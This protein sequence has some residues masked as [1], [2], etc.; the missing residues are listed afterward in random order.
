MNT[1]IPRIT[2]TGWSVPFAIRKNDDPIFDWLRKN[3]PDQD[4]FEGYDE[5]HVLQPNEGL[6]DIMVP[7]AIMALE[8]AGK[9]P[10]DI[11]ILLGLGSISEYV[12]PNMLTQVHKELGLSSNAWVIPIGNDYSNYASCLLF[13]D[14]LVKAGKAENV[15]IC[16]GGNWTRNVDYHTP[17]SISAADGAGAAVVSLSDDVSKWF[18]ADY[19][20]VTN[21]AN[22]GTMFTKAAEYAVS[23]LIGYPKIYSNHF[24]QITGEGLK[25]FGTFGMQQA[26]TAVL[27]LLKKNNL[28]GDDISFMPHQTSQ[29][30]VDYWLKQIVPQPA[31]CL[32]TMKKFAN[33]TVATHALNLA[34]FEENKSIQKDNL[35]MLALGPDMHA[36]AMLLK[37]NA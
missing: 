8:N 37:R 28:T 25:D 18:V 9:Q 36:N 1:L 16:I 21:S 5:R 27:E 17:Q 33:V 35:V 3:L 10:D 22:Y 4:M 24:F 34:W 30:L 31:Q 19:C 2:G 23:D 12:Q 29:V 26:A 6:I 15:L 20:T 11:D 13:A 14:A 32:S 7:A